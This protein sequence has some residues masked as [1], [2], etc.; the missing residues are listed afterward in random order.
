MVLAHHF[1]EYFEPLEDIA[2]P[3]QW[4]IFTPESGPD[5]LSESAWAHSSREEAPHENG[6]TRLE[7]DENRSLESGGL[8]ARVWPSFLGDGIYV[9][10]A[11]YAR[12][13]AARGLPLSR[14]SSPG[15]DESLQSSRDLPLTG[16][17]K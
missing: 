12:V 17:P 7:R 9:E 6:E 16:S 8:N 2:K 4:F 11:L 1:R 15:P 10:T 14:S 5:M 13:R 3:S